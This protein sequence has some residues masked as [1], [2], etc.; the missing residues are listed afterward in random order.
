MIGERILELLVGIKNPISLGAAPG[1]SAN[2][3]QIL[4]NQYEGKCLHGSYI[5][6]V[7]HIV[8]HG[9]IELNDTAEPGTGTIW[10]KFAART[11]TFVPGE[12][13]HGCKITRIDP[14]GSR[15]ICEAPI[16]TLSFS[17]VNYQGLAV[18]MLVSVV[19]NRVRHS[20]NM[21][22]A[23]CI[24]ELFV[25]AIRSNIIYKV[26]ATSAQDAQIFKPL[27]ERIKVAD[28]KLAELTPKQVETFAKILHPYKEMPPKRAHAAYRSIL[29]LA[30]KG[31]SNDVTYIGC[32]ESL[33]LL[34]P[35]VRIFTQPELGY[36]LEDT[37][38]KDQIIFRLLE[39]YCNHIEAVAAYGSI[40]STAELIT[41]HKKLW[42]IFQFNKR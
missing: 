36:A 2:L 37:F 25:P 19:I 40:Y 20:I 3:L 31:L 14:A 6:T 32:D 30:E 9:V 4:K 22:R 33:P 13:L 16:V 35:D 38:N 8:R 18:D 11:N 41:T 7:L 39:E 29:T 28:A 1:I 17:M 23:S 24:G 12:I 27:L 26:P 34:D 10:V 21:D 42:L 15:A 5:D